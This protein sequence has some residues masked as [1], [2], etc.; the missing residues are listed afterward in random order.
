MSE[1][2]LTC[3]ELVELVTE[4]FEDALPPER[5]ARFESHLYGC[6]GCQAFVEQMRQT[7]R[8]VGRLTEDEIS[9]EARQKL[10]EAFR[11]WKKS[12]PPA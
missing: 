10:L 6:E 11:N 5:R 7:V 8:L 9:P 12:G 4:Y 2:G 1:H 3:Q